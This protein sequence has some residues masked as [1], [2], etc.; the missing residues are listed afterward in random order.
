MVI[1]EKIYLEAEM[2]KQYIWL[3]N[4]IELSYF[5][6]GRAK[7]YWTFSSFASDI[8]R[9]P[10]TYTIKT[11]SFW[12]IFS[13]QNHPLV[14]TIRKYGGKFKYRSGFLHIKYYCVV[15]FYYLFLLSIYD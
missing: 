14:S 1:H 8:Q 13:Y 2:K 12:N 6:L 5:I 9:F 10:A 3:K 7:L 4:N 15:F 11:T